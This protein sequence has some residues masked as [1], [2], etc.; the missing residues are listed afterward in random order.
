[1]G[2]RKNLQRINANL[3]KLQKLVKISVNSLQKLIIW[4]RNPVKF[5]RAEKFY[6][7][8]LCIFAVQFLRQI[9]IVTFYLK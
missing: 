3:H 9:C 8:A 2:C 4:Q 1:M 6:P 5:Q 7:G